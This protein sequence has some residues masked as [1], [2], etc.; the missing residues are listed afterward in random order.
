M[1]LGVT[2]DFKVCCRQ[3]GDQI[4]LL[5]QYSE[6]RWKVAALAAK[7]VLKNAKLQVII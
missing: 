6:N 3:A 2:P 5:Q 1:E 7:I 4:I